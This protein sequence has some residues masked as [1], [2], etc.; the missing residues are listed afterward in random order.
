M[1]YLFTHY[2]SEFSSKEVLF[3]NSL[4]QCRIKVIIVWLRKLVMKVHEC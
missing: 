3:S 2:I 4:Q 1:I